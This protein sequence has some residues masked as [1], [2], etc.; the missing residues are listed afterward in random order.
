MVE[1][2]ASLEDYLEAIYLINQDKKVV[3]VKEVAEFLDVKTPSVVDAVSKLSE[4]ELVIHEKYG[5][6]TLSKKGNEAAKIIYNKHEQIFKFLNE[7]LGMDEEI[8]QKDACALE[9]HISKTSME[10]MIQLMKFLESKPDEY[11][12]WISDFNDFIKSDK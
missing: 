4:K 6:L 11:E 2:S 10:K 3:R 8:S 7:V 5:Y 1:L 9:H 12:K